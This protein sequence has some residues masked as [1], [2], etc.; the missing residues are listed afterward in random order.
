Q[1]AQPEP[2]L[3]QPRLHREACFRWIAGARGDECA[4]AGNA[5]RLAVDI[6]WGA[7]GV[8]TERVVEERQSSVHLV[9]DD[10]A[11]SNALNP[12]DSS[13]LSR[14]VA[15][16]TGGS[17]MPARTAVDEVHA[18]AIGDDCRRIGD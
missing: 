13:E 15:G 16:A 3:I 8:Q 18:V 1:D 14:S 17:E 4:V 7:N 12:R 11:G 2:R 6:V 9:E 5:A 10:D